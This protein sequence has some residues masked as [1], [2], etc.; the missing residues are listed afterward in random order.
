MPDCFLRRERK[1]MD[2]GGQGEGKAL[3]G[4]GGGGD[5]GPQSEYIVLNTSIFN[6]RKIAKKKEV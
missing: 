3:G 5:G 4:V 2:L 1:D 6:K